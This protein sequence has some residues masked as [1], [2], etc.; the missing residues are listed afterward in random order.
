MVDGDRMLNV[1]KSFKLLPEKDVSYLKIN[2]GEEEFLVKITA[3]FSGKFIIEKLDDKKLEKRKPKLNLLLQSQNFDVKSINIPAAVSKKKKTTLFYIKHKIGLPEK[4]VFKYQILK[5]ELKESEVQIFLVEDSIYNSVPEDVMK[6]LEGIY[7]FQIG[8]INIAS[9]FSNID[10]SSFVILLYKGL[11]YTA[12][13]QGKKIYFYRETTYNSDTELYESILLTYRYVQTIVNKIGNVIVISEDNRDIITDLGLDAYISEGLMMININFFIQKTDIDNVLSIISIFSKTSGI[14]FIPEEI[15]LS[16]NSKRLLKLL[17]AVYI[18]S[19]I[20]MGKSI[21]E[22]YT[23]VKT[24]SDIIH[25]DFSQIKKML[26]TIA[27]DSSI[28]EVAQNSLPLI[29]KRDNLV[30]SINSLLNVSNYIDLEDVEVTFKE[31]EEN[32]VLL[33]VKGEK[34]FKKL[35]EMIRF[36]NKIKNLEESGFILDI[37]KDYTKKS[38]T[39][40]IKR[41]F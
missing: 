37:N 22:T 27:Q 39:F 23:T 31:E 10:S 3:L 33:S 1:K 11:L 41:K 34:E 32:S 40:E 18:V 14:N 29:K 24:K 21:Y 17:S 20:F 2:L 15:I 5:S 35:D 16:R 38:L 25:R 36:I 8:L 6:N 30:L 26:G 19:S 12:V 7:L 9:T 4:T 28:L 13:A